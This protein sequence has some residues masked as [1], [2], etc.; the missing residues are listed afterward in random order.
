MLIYNIASGG[1]SVYKE[2]VLYVYSFSYAAH[3]AFIVTEK[4]CNTCLFR[5]Q[6]IYFFI[7]TLEQR[8]SLIFLSPYPTSPNLLLVLGS[9]HIGLHSPLR[10]QEPKC[11]IRNISPRLCKSV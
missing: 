2:R 7:R 1:M 6:N 10:S 3:Y 4:N 11:S 8:L 9:A 5:F